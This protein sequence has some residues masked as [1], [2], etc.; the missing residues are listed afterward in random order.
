MLAE[1]LLTPPP[2]PKETTMRFPCGAMAMALIL[3]QPAAAQVKVAGP[4]AQTVDQSW[5]GATVQKVRIVVQTG[6]DDLRD[7]SSFGI[8][9]QLRDGRRL[10]KER[11]N[12]HRQGGDSKWR[13]RGMGNN[14]QRSFEWVLVDSLPK[15]RDI[16]S[17]G[18]GY[19]SG[20]GNAFDSPDNWNMQ[21]LQVQVTARKGN[22]QFETRV[23]YSCTKNPLYRFKDSG[24][25]ESPQL[26]PG[27]PNAGACR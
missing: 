18:V 6:S 14:V 22:G 11:L 5:E 4:P 3:A 24:E 26:D 15:V 10:L 25:W 21:R 19:W 16:Q 20:G 23:L 8:F 17:V 9:L 12:C 1:V 7:G 13:C 27:T 2:K